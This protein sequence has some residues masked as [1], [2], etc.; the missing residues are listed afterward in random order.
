MCSQ[1]RLPDDGRIGGAVAVRRGSLRP[2][3]RDRV[4]GRCRREY[5]RSIRPGASREGQRPLPH[6]LRVHASRMDRM[7][8]SKAELPAPALPRHD[9]R[10]SRL[11]HVASFWKGESMPLGRLISAPLHSPAFQLDQANS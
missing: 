11:P 2:E 10:R 9:P 8:L 1:V 7:G 4:R 6:Q 3:I 5:P